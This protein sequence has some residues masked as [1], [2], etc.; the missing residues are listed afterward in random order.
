MN[1]E[2]LASIIHD[3]WCNWMIYFMPRIK[4][5]NQFEKKRWIRLMST[6]YKD[7]TDHEKLS[8]LEIV[9]KFFSM[10]VDDKNEKN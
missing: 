2:E 5:N 1:R 7:L 8:D 6:K 3:I 9:D 10:L 4:V